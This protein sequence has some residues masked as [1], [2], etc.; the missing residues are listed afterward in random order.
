M[1]RRFTEWTYPIVFAL[2]ALAVIGNARSHRE[3]RINPLVTAVTIALIVRWAGFF[4]ANQVQVSPRL[5]PIVYLI[6]LTFAAISIWFIVTNRT[7]ELPVALADR[8]M[9]G[10]RQSATA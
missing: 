9:S 8:L 1:H 6:P 2:I 10:L 4:A 3:G 5:W 7:M